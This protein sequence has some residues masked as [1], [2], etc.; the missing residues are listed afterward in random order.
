MAAMEP[1]AAERLTVALARQAQGS[2]AQ[3]ANASQ[4]DGELARLPAPRR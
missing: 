4:Q 2:P 3:E 1:A